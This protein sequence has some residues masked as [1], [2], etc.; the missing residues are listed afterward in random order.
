MVWMKFNP[1]MENGRPTVLLPFPQKDWAEIWLNEYNT[2][3]TFHQT[4]IC[5]QEKYEL[6][7]S[8]C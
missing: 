4:D 2:R 5:D 6:N 3:L 8:Y 7:I 1:E